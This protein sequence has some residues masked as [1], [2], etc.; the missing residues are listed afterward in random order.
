MNI[1]HPCP[2]QRGKTIVGTAL[3]AVVGFTAPAVGQF[4]EAAGFAD[5]MQPDLF[6]RDLVV[7]S[8]VLELDESQRLIVEALFTDHQEDF[9][10]GLEN[11]RNRFDEMRDDFTGND[12]KRI[13]TLVFLP[14]QEWRGEKEILRQEFME[15]VK[16]VLTEEQLERWPSL[17]R[18]LLREKSLGKGR[19]SGERV[20]L[21]HVVRDLHL[22]PPLLEHLQPLL[23]EYEL[24]LDQA[25]RRRNELLANS[26]ESIIRALREQDGA[27]G[28]KVVGQQIETRIAVRDTNDRYI[29]L[30]TAALPETLGLQF[31]AMARERAYPRVFRPTIEQR[32]FKAAEALKELEPD[33]LT[34]V[35][36]LHQ[37]YLGELGIINEELLRQLRKTEPQ[38]ALDRA[39][40][41]ATRLRGE[42]TPKKKAGRS[43]RLD[44]VW[45]RDLGHRY[46]ALLDDI[47]TP[48]QAASLP[49]GRRVTKYTRK[50]TDEAMRKKVADQLRGLGAAPSLEEPIGESEGEPKARKKKRGKRSR[51]D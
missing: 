23:L 45:R 42:A 9:Q 13:M 30:I 22:D 4:G 48:E 44:L 34:A 20:N 14:F 6:S 33:V 41:F 8:E 26:Q 2:R 36:E 39:E 28:V 50:K 15:N 1:V 32:I 5:S 29:E 12:V 21:L 49:G 38:L 3:A 7:F 51:G 43:T 17:E 35:Q 46:T 18:R 25:L 31:R 11:M 10:L 19:L 16:V 40:A 27:L 24:V 37:T 47:L